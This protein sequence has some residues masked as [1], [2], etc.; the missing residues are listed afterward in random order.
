MAARSGRLHLSHSEKDVGS[1]AATTEKRKNGTCSKPY[2][3]GKSMVELDLNE[4]RRDEVLHFV[5]TAI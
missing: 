2:R 5:V 1:L 3:V 4:L